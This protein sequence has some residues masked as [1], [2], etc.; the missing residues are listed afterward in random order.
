MAVV[1]TRISD[2][3]GYNTPRRPEI[4]SEDRS[5][6]N[7]R[8]ISC[9]RAGLPGLACYCPAAFVR[10]AHGP[11]CRCKSR[12]RCSGSARSIRCSGVCWVLLPCRFW[13]VPSPPLPV[14][15]PFVC[16]ICIRHRL[17]PAVSFRNFIL[18]WLRCPF[19]VRLFSHFKKKW[20]QQFN[21]TQ[22]C[23]E[24]CTGKST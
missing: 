11:R 5:S 14:A 7:R 20:A 3:S 17:P 10:S 4:R 6:L 18:L 22:K 2:S 19:F 15:C 1:E 8:M 16:G 13:T 23:E 24:D 12:R 9:A 21:I